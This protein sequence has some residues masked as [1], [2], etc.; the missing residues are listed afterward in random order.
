MRDH[1]LEALQRRALPSHRQG[2]PD[3]AGNPADQALSIL[4]A[5]VA[6]A[7]HNDV[8]ARPHRRDG[9]EHVFAGDPLKVGCG[10]ADIVYIAVRRPLRARTRLLGA[11]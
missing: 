2:P 5:Q 9:T 10:P 4:I 3:P 6:T 7:H 11:P 8:S 1:V